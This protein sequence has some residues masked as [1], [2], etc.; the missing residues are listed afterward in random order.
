MNELKKEIKQEIKEEK[1]IAHIAPVDKKHDIINKIEALKSRLPKKNGTLNDRQVNLLLDDTKDIIGQTIGE[2]YV[3]G[4]KNWNVDVAQNLKPSALKALDKEEKLWVHQLQ[5]IIQEL[6]DHNFAEIRD[7]LNHLEEE[8]EEEIQKSE[9]NLLDL[10][11]NKD[12]L[13]DLKSLRNIISEIPDEDHQMDR[14]LRDKIE[15]E[16][17]HF[18]R[19][20]VE[21]DGI[22]MKTLEKSELNDYDLTPIEKNDIMKLK[23][24]YDQLSTN[25]PIDND[26]FAKD[27]KKVMNELKKE[28]KQEIKEEKK[29]AHIAP[30]DKK[31][32][33]INKIEA[34][35][36]RLPKKNGTLNDRQ[37]NLLLDDTK[38][39]IGQIIGEKY[40]S[41]LKNWNVDVAQNLKPSAL[42]ALDKEEKLWVKQL[43]TII[44]E[45]KDHNFAEIRDELNHL[46]EEV[47]EEIQKSE[48]NLLDLEVNKDRL[49]DLKSLRNIISE[50]PD[51]DHQMDRKLRDKIEAEIEH[52]VRDFVEDDGIE[53]K[54]LEKSMLKDYDLTP[55]EKNDIM[56]LKE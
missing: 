10:E 53:M 26:Q 23:E 47:E 39:I 32:D 33:I 9:Q 44:Q 4:L 5:T 29:I 19:D 16:I 36:S 35:K 7:E 27:M 28:I 40:V 51:E 50:I 48:Q 20:F 56:K 15:A 3:S 30:V 24:L 41:G 14:K 46:E 42:K 38:D 21:D 12:R 55:T 31:H 52:F 2:K 25:K 45:L 11:V 34:L 22:E 17:E 13:E 18:V 1:K 49:E 6:K 43:Q 54:T 37:V 8:V